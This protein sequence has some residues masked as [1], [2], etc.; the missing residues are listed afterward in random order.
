MAPKKYQVQLSAE[1]L[2]E[3]N[4]LIRWGRLNA[5]QHTRALVLLKADEGL[6]DSQI[7]AVVQVSRPT[8]ERIRR[9]FAEGGLERA[10]N[11]APRPGQRRRLDAQAEAILI[12]TADS[13]APDG[14]DHWAVRLLA[15]RLVE[16]GVVESISPETVRLALNKCHRE[17]SKPVAAIRRPP[18]RD[19]GWE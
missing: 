1:E 15:D 11:E 18:Q 14:H 10:L 13:Q 3:L 5:R 19:S 12:T 2:R 8:V 6:S 9:R 16:L 4:E 7:T 17:Q